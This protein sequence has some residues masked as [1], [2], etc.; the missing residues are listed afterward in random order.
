MLK[1]KFAK[2]VRD[3]IVSN[4]LASGAKPSFRQLS[5][6]EHKRALI[7]KII[8][9]AGEIIQATSDTVVAEIADVQQALDDLKAKY[10]ITDKAV[11][12][13]Q[14]LKNDKNGAF[15]K[16]H[17]IEYVE[18]DEG[19]PWADYYRANPDRYPEIK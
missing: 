18:V 11:R 9:E 12:Q 10:G 8:E 19:D 1:F 4:Q 15:Q 7:N 6:D 14:Q 3:K 5:P 2:L 16:G 17:F 13:A